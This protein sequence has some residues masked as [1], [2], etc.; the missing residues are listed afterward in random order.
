[1][2]TVSVR[3]IPTGDDLDLQRGDTWSITFYRL[4]NIS[5]RDKLWFTLKDDKDDTDATAWVQIEES[6]GL[7]YIAGAAASTS[8]NGSIAVTDAALG[9]LTV[10]LAAVESAKLAD[11]GNLYYGVQ[12]LD[13][14]VVTTMVSGRAVMM[15]DVTRETS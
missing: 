12:M 13:D 5:G 14:P 15:G 9:N 1:M 7:E 4:G 10:T 2:P 8:A 6:A 3:T 11:V